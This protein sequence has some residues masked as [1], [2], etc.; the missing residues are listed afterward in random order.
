MRGLLFA[1]LCDWYVMIW[2]V[3]AASNS[4]GGCPPPLNLMEAST[5]FYGNDL[6]IQY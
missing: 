4:C 2:Y 6:P 3:L 1:L 5:V